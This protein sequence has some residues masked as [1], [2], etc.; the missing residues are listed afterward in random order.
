[1]MRIERFETLLNTHA[2][3][4]AMIQR[5]T[6]GPSAQSALG[7]A[8]AIDVMTGPISTLTQLADMDKVKMRSDGGP[9][10][11]LVVVPYRQIREKGFEYIDDHTP[12]LSMTITDHQTMP[13]HELVAALPN[14]VITIN[15]PRFDLEDE[16]YQRLV[17]TILDDEIAM[18]AGANFVLKREFQCQIEGF[19]RRK[20]LSLFRHLVENESGAYWTYLIF[21]GEQYLIGAT[22]EQHITLNDGYAAMNPISGTYRYPPSGPQ[23]SGLER[24]LTD[25]KE[26]DEL[27]MVVDEELKMMSSVCGEGAAVSGPYIKAMSKLA[28]TE[29]MIR[30]RSVLTPS[31]ILRQTLFAPTITGSPLEN[32]CR[33]IKKYEPQGRGYYSGLIALIGKDGANRDTLDSAIVIRSAEIRLNGDLRLGVGST[34]VR[35][36]VPQQE[37]AESRAKAQGFLSAI[38]ASLPTKARRSGTDT[39]LFTQPDM[40][41]TLRSRNQSLSQFWLAQPQPHECV[42]PTSGGYRVLVLDA[43]DTFTAMIAHQLRALRCH[44]TVKACTEEFDTDDHDLV[45]LGPGPGAPDVLADARVQA[46]NR[47]LNRLLASKKPF[48]AVCLSHQVL[49]MNL[50]FEI[51]RRTH[52]N[53][54]L[55]LPIDWFGQTEK[56]GFYNAFSAYVPQDHRERFFCRDI[57]ISHDHQ[58][59]EIHALRGAHFASFQF[60]PESILTQRGLEIWQD[61]LQWLVDCDDGLSVTHHAVA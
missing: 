21:T 3:P 18:G 40:L 36:S 47:T 44:V 23:R 26:I 56:V 28:H 51:R 6:G 7:T 22:P 33:V 30:G 43:E 45:V 10:Q 14:D 8:N 20:A 57:R 1:M 24:F 50:G 27:F 41:K 29:Y 19:N 38:H 48:I 54:G 17:A 11:Q 2:Q 46:I 4:F 58:S 61:T 25:Q 55:Q 60:H 34:L 32:A 35:H 42:Q 9:C 13:A 15:D 39:T 5:S 52:P 31:A 59:R 49:C 12:L 37:A 53:Q 16:A